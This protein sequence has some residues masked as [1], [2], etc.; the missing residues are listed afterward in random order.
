MIDLHIHTIHSDGSCTPG[1][2]LREAEASGLHCI[3]ITDHNSVGAYFDPIL[4]DEPFSGKLIP[5]IEITC[6]FEGEVV[7]VLGYGINISSMQ[8]ELS[9]HV[10][11]FERKQLQE[12]KLIL[13]HF[14]QIGLLFNKENI[15]FDPKR[16]SCRK[17]FL[18]ELNRYPENRCYF[19]E[20][21]SW[22]KSKKF[23][24]QEIYNPESPLYVD[25]SS[26]YPSVETAV[27]MIHRCGGIAFWAH[28]Y[29]YAH[30]EIFR[31][32]LDR[33]VRQFGLDGMECY[34]SDFTSDQCLDLDAF[35]KAHGLLRS[36]GSDYHG[37]RKPNTPMGEPRV[38]E[39][40]MDN[41]PEIMIF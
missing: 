9:K 25:E 5:G 34:H 1:E 38:V 19:L 14:S 11:S 29:I 39:A 15:Q 35:C 8:E 36:G 28:L 18:R 2:I 30:A 3:S 23:A 40:I 31:S 7:E 20:E 24:R 37:T 22:L 33:L 12:Y 6:L 13:N 4:R 26:L 17:S 41:W 10:L 27:Q 16:E 32:K 21:D